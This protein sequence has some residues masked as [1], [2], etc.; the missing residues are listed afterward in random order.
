M[1]NAKFSTHQEGSA[2]REKGIFHTTRGSP[3]IE[4]DD[5]EWVLSQLSC[6]L[7]LP[8][9]R[10]IIEKRQVTSGAEKLGAF[11][12]AVQ[13]EAVKRSENITVTYSKTADDNWCIGIVTGIETEKCDCMDTDPATADCK[14]DGQVRIINDSDMMYAG[15]MGSDGW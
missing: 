9:Y 2:E 3:L 8:S 15:I 10:S 13:M 4:A 6:S 12:S 7:A 11:L 1:Q 5:R 14:I